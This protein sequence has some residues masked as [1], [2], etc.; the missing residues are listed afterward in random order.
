MPSEEKYMKRCLDLAKNG[1]GNTYPNP[2]V[3]SVIVYKDKIIGEGYHTKSGENHAEIN[4][5][6]SVKDKSLLKKST[7]YVNLEPCS[8]YG[9]TPPCAKRIADL[10]IPRVVI[11][12]LDTTD[13]VSGKGVKILKEAGVEVKVNVLRNESRELNKRFFTFHEKKRPY[14]I[15]KWA[16]T[17]DGF[18]DI[19]RTKD[20]PIEPNWITGKIERT[21]V[22]KWRA[23]EQSI[24]VG[25]NTVAKDNP[26]LTT[27]NW[28]G[29]NPVRLFI[30]KK[31]Q[32][33]NDFYLL[34]K[35]VKTVCFNNIKENIND[36]NMQ[37]VK[38]NISKNSFYQILDYL[39]K[40]N[41]QSIIVEGGQ[42]LLQSVIDTN[43]WDE[44]RI[45]IGD[46]QFI[47]GV[48]SPEISCKIDKTKVFKN[49]KLIYF[50][51]KTQV[52]I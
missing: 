19:K 13:K 20:S 30:D 36:E 34:D 46:V 45:F 33:E 21:L 48:K 50:K 49:S 39:Y 11:G 8:H 29:K 52:L 41:L 15:L 3:G 12:T 2:L 44:A 38:F 4:A 10:Q 40:A 1:L 51:N 43:I 47:N 31:L 32:I 7:L 28:Y 6:N 24:V 27:R 23:E 14:V 18:I 5:I 37:F 25:T 9:K 17:A 22:H 16:Q 42:K 35:S 26:S